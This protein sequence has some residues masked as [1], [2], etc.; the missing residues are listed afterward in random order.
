[1]L[2]PAHAPPTPPPPS[3]GDL[4]SGGGGG[5][6]GLPLRGG[7]LALHMRRTV[8]AWWKAGAGLVAAAGPY[9]MSTGCACVVVAFMKH[10]AGDTSERFG[11]KSCERVGLGDAQAPNAPTKHLGEALVN[12]ALVVGLSL[13][14]ASALP[15]LLQLFA[16]R[17]GA[18]GQAGGATPS[19]G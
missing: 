10:G 17:G 14:A 12:P 6:G 3:S 5:G 16:G 8:W 15:L 4:P 19:A 2:K 7:A 18:P 11:L 1:M 9:V 13:V